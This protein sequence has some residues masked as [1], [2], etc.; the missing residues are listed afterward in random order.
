LIWGCKEKA[1]GRL[2]FADGTVSWDHCKIKFIPSSQEFEVTDLGS[3]NGTF[4]LPE[5]K[6][7]MAQKKYVFKV[8]KMIR[9]SKKMNLS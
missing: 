2:E 6:R 3:S 1:E 7:M 5:E 9:L 8:G 4:S